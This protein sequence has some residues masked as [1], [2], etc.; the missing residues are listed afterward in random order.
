MKA[1]IEED[2]RTPDD[3]FV[4]RYGGDIINENVMIDFNQI[5]KII[6]KEDCI[7]EVVDEDN[8]MCLLKSI[9][10]KDILD[11]SKYKKYYRCLINENDDVSKYNIAE[12]PCM[13]LCNNGRIS[14]VINGYYEEKD[15][16]KLFEL[17]K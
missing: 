16:E 8:I 7:I 11:N 5:N 6:S 17:L 2:P 9:T 10:Y 1:I 3:L 14:K 12:L 13:I 4:D 15:K